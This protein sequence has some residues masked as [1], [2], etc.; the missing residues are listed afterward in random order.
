[1]SA[2]V[3][4][5]AKKRHYLLREDFDELMKFAGDAVPD[6]TPRPN[7]GSSF[8]YPKNTE[9]AF[10]ELRIRGLEVDG[11]KL[12]QMAKDGIVSPQGARSAMTWT[13]EDWLEWSK[14]DID[15]AAEWLYEH[16][17][18]NPWTHFCWLCN[19]RFAQCVKAHRLAA[20]RYGWGWSSG[21]DVLGRNFYVERAKDPNEYA[22]IRF[23]PDDFDF[24]AMEEGK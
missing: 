16:E 8:D 15:Q 10:R 4:G 1:M 13:G 2:S 14:E 24:D 9:G 19:L 22:F 18:W 7:S 17:R 21:F 20:A 3:E 5:S 23:L 6:P 11:L 12:W